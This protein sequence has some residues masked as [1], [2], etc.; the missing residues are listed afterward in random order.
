M[1]VWTANVFVD[2]HVVDENGVHDQGQHFSNLGI[3]DW[4]TWVY[5][6]RVCKASSVGHE[7]LVKL[8]QLF[9]TLWAHVCA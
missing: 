4:N 2:G 5:G 7:D 6:A 1:S 3:G 8:E 9:K